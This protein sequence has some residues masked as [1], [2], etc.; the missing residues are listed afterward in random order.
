MDTPFLSAVLAPM[1]YS[2]PALFQGHNKSHV[3]DRT[4]A[5]CQDGGDA[6][7]AVLCSPSSA[8]ARARSGC[9]SNLISR[10]HTPG[11]LTHHGCPSNGRDGCATL[12]VTSATAP[13]ARSLAR[14][15]LRS[16]SGHR[17]GAPPARRPRR[18]EPS[19]A[20]LPGRGRVCPRG[21][22][23]EPRRGIRRNGISSSPELQNLRYSEYQPLADS[24]EGGVPCRR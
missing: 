2:Q 17:S 13:P 19:S 10:R 22:T 21:Q 8:A 20:P 24:A 9:R 23:W 1:V 6:P 7:G 12:G 15:P 3:V 14:S 11:A 18:E 16:S 5:L 4:Q